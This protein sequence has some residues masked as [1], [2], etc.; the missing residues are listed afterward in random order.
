MTHKYTETELVGLSDTHLNNL[1]NI[2]VEKIQTLRKEVEELD[3]SIILIKQ[4]Q[5]KRRGEK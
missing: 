4:V 5:N 1:K 3:D 2:Y